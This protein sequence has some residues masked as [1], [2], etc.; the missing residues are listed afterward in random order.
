MKKILFLLFFNFLFANEYTKQLN[1]LFSF[2]NSFF[3]TNNLSLDIFN[4]KCD[5]SDFNTSNQL[6]FAR[7]KYFSENL[8]I[9]VDG[10]AD[11]DGDFKS[12]FSLGVRWNLLNNGY[13]SNKNKAKLIILKNQLKNIDK[14]DEFHYFLKY[15]KIIYYFNQQK[16]KL[17]TKYLEYLKLK[18]DIFRYRY[19][20]HTTTL[21]KLLLIKQSIKN[22]ENLINTYKIFNSKFVCKKD[23]IGDIFDFDLN[24]NEIIEDI[25][26]NHS[27]KIAL[28]NKILN[29]E[30]DKYKQWN[31]NLY[32]KKNFETGKEKLGFGFS[33]PLTPKTDEIK[34]LEKLKFIEDITKEDIRLFL[35]IQKNYYTFRYKLSDLIKMKFKLAYVQTQ[36]KRAK[37]RYKFHIGNDNLDRVISNVDAIF[38]IKLQLLDLKQ[39]LV[40][41]TFSLLNSLKLKYKPNYIKKIKIDTNLQLRKGNRSLYI[42]ANGFKMYEN[43]ILIEF[44]KLKNLKNFIVSVSHN[45][46]FKKLKKFMSLAKQNNIKVEF[47]IFD[48][49]WLFHN[50]EIDEKMIFLNQFKNYNLNIF[51]ASDVV[52][53]YNKRFI[54]IIKYLAYKY[55]KYKLN[56]TIPYLKDDI[57]KQIKPFVN[58][59]YSFDKRYIGKDVNLILNCEKYKNELEL[60]LAI[61]KIVTKNHNI[62]LYD[63]KTY[64]KELK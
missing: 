7:Y 25:D 15:N 23:F 3:P 30:F 49:A 28:N 53:K 37:L 44:L 57:L 61:D 5:I 42:W 38:A 12:S 64:I 56:I 59:I 33:I 47:L 54:E 20:L 60:E 1:E 52:Y 22:N 48:N 9:F 35:Y 14:T 58:N 17:L 36:L 63:F 10:G 21:D 41:Q 40:L 32:A 29:I 18:F 46:D 51:L 4:D 19:W 8:G 13:Q 27:K 50:D 43:N 34:K 55:P 62:S 39:Q 24:Y 16:I 31:L 6:D 11:I 2:A 26:I 45:Q